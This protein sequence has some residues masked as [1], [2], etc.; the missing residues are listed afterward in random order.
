MVSFF[1]GN[2]TK[3]VIAADHLPVF[4]V[5]GRNPSGKP[6][7]THHEIGRLIARNPEADLFGLVTQHVT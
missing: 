4:A 7:F 3:E 6:D 1:H 2:N 5:Y